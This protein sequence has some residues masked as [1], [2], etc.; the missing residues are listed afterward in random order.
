VAF[1]QYP[2]RLAADPRNQ[3]TFDRL[4]GHQ[5]HRPAGTSLWR[6]TAYHGND[7]LLLGCIQNLAGSGALLV[8]QSPLQSA[9]SVAMRQITDSL[10][11][12]G[13]ALSNLGSVHARGQLLQRKGTQ[14]DAHLLNTTP[15]QGLDFGQILS[16]HT[17]G[18]R[19]T[20]HTDRIAQDAHTGQ[21]E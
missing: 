3:F 7:T 6:L 9:L 20:C 10:W 17:K 21:S 19:W 5:A 15:Q 16:F 4:S 12:Q 1:Q 13:N 18:D 8:V 14:D 2:Y 11:R